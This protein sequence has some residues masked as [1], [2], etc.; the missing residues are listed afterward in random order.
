MG[1][2]RYEASLLGKCPSLQKGM[3]V[4]FGQVFFDYL[5]DYHVTTKQGMK[6]G[7]TIQIFGA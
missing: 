2:S 3:S 1:L 4:V 7:Y 6:R 5:K